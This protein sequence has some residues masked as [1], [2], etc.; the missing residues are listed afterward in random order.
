MFITSDSKSNTLLSGP[1]LTFA[2]KTETLGSLYIYAVLTLTESPKSKN[3]V[4]HEQKF[5]DLLDVAFFTGFFCFHLVKSPMPILALLPINVVCLWKPRVEFFY[6]TWRCYVF[7][8]SIRKRKTEHKVR[9]QH[10]KKQNE[11]YPLAVL[12]KIKVI[13]SI[14]FCISFYTL[15]SVLSS[16]LWRI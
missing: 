12:H 15:P 6:L 5:K 1:S 10:G 13:C 3:K 9:Q 8:T 4:V 7:Q 11:R 2:C 14:S 16:Y